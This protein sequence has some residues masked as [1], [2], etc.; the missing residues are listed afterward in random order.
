MINSVTIE[1]Y[2]INEMLHL[3]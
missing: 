3:T 2:F 1:T